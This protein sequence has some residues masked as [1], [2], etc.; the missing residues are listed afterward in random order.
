MGRP[1]AWRMEHA[2]Y[3]PEYPEADVK[4]MLTARKLPFRETADPA[5]DGTVLPLLLPHAE[6]T[7]ASTARI[8]MERQ[9]IDT[10][11]PHLT[12]D[13]TVKVRRDAVN[14]ATGRA[15]GSSRPVRTG[16]SSSCRKFR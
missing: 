8:T 10:T 4:G 6:M 12:R 3:G 16:S 1:R 7:R 9:R 13:L 2:F 11:R 14:A 15:P 5:A